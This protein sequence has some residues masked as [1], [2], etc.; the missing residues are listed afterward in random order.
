MIF[1]YD[2]WLIRSCA[3]SQSDARLE[4]TYITNLDFNMEI[5]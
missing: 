5:S 2:F 4:Y 1:W 3:A